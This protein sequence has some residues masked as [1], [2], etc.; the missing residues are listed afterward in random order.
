MERSVLLK[1]AVNCK[2]CIAFSV[3]E[4]SMSTVHWWNDTDI[5]HKPKIIYIWKLRVVAGVFNQMFVITN[6]I[7][8]IFAHYFDY[9]FCVNFQHQVCSFLL[10]RMVQLHWAA[11]RWRVRCQQECS[12]KWLWI[13][14]TG[15]PQWTTCTLV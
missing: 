4:W 15:N 11:M 13:Q 12:S 14:T 3:F 1:S 5:W 9:N 10:Q 8:F 6:K 2:S 7:I